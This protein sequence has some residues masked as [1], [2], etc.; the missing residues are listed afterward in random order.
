MKILRDI[1]EMHSLARSLHAGNK[2][3]GLVPTMGALH[4][5]HVSLLS[6]SHERMDRTV[7]SVFVN[8]TQFGPTEDFAKYPRPFDSDCAK[9]ETAGC[10]I[11]FAPEPAAM[12]PEHYATYVTVDAL[13]RQLCG[14]TR[15]D[16]FRGVATVV[17][18]LFNIVTPDTAYFGAKDAQ[19][20]IVLRRMIADLNLSIELEVC[21]TVRESDGL[22]MSSR[23]GYL[24]PDERAAAPVIFRGLQEAAARFGQG[25][26]SAAALAAIIERHLLSGTLINKEYIEIVDTQTLSAC[27]EITKTALV[28][29]ACRTAESKTRLIDSITLGGSL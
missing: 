13:S 5:G 21:P 27:S 8:P 23:N 4:Q 18:K 7:M 20:V 11:V 9:A 2:T 29:I 10:D 6:R 28:A 14:I 17:F 3:I 12:Y 26:R 19:Q 24:T 22:A 1:G 25:E 16:H 15:P